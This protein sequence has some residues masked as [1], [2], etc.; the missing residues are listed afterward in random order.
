MTINR[1]LAL[2]FILS[3]SIAGCA[4]KAPPRIAY[5]GA[6]SVG[7]IT[8][9]MLLGNW[10]VTVLNPHEGEQSGVTDVSYDAGGTMVMNASPS[11]PGMEMKLRMTGTWQIQGDLVSQT[12]ET[13]EDTSGSTL[14][15]LLKPLMAGIKNRATG[16]ANIFE[17]SADR[18]VLVSTN[19]GQAL[20]YT[21]L[22]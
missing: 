19:D 2:V 6:D 18:I 22:P 1:A 10:S 14:G 5:T 11:A 20:E 13:I 17:A 12:L 15:S 7:A 8:S 21:R 3:L 16:T 4:T 9:D